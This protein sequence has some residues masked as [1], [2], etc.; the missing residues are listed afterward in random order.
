MPGPGRSRKG[1]KKPSKATDAKSTLTISRQ[2]YLELLAKTDDWPGILVLTYH[3]FGIPDLYTKSGFKKIHEDFE[4]VCSRLDAAYSAFPR[5]EKVLG[6]IALIYGYMCSDG[7][8]K[9]KILNEK[10]IRRLL[11]LIEMEFCRLVVLQTLVV[12]TNSADPS[13]K[14]LVAQ[15]ASS[16]VKILTCRPQDPTLVDAAIILLSEV[17]PALLTAKQTPAAK[18]SRRIDIP[19]QLKEVMGASK[20][21]GTSSYALSFIPMLLHPI[22]ELDRAAALGNPMV[23]RFLVACLRNKDWI[24]RV[25]LE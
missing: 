2:A 10:L 18:S 13:L 24:I 11:P 14:A 23:P 20:E 21:K 16:L 8:L 17:V 7:I 19:S 15:E 5:H 25:L 1:G 6:S 3:H 12:V 9:A 4:G 22:C